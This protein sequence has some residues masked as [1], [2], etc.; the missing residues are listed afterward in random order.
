MEDWLKVNDVI[1]D[2]VKNGE[3]YQVLQTNKNIINTENISTK[4]SKV[5]DLNIT[6]VYRVTNYVG[7]LK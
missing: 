1:T 2:V 4:E 7:E 6:Q 3:L 5:F